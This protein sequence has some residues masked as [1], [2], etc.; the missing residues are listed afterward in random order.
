[1]FWGFLPPPPPQ[2]TMSNNFYHIISIFVLILNLLTYPK[3]GQHYRNSGPSAGSK[4][5]KV[6]WS[7]WANLI[8]SIFIST[9]PAI[10]CPE[11]L[12]SD[13]M[14]KK[15]YNFFFA[16]QTIRLQE[17]FKVGTSHQNGWDADRHG[18]QMPSE[19]FFSNISITNVLANPLHFF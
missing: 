2:P 4:N 11:F 6:G 7:I 15:L 18:I 17:S 5:L 13:K 12:L 10:H 1:M 8:F 14:S 9:L 16:N 3:I 19:G